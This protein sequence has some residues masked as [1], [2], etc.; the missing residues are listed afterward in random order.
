MTCGLLHFLNLDVSIT[1]LVQSVAVAA[2]GVC[3]NIDTSYRK[4]DKP[5]SLYT[6]TYMIYQPLYYS[7]FTVKCTVCVYSS[8][9]V[10]LETLFCLV[11]G[12]RIAL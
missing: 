4:G 10:G 8:I 7:V 3:A 5:F 2:W 12:K 1:E 11:L 6:D 9:C